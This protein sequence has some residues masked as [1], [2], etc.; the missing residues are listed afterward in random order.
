MVTSR[1]L[2]ADH[3]LT[4]LDRHALR[5]LLGAFLEPFQDWPRIDF[6]RTTGRRDSTRA[7]R[8]HVEDVSTRLGAMRVAHAS[9]PRLRR[10]SRGS[11]LTSSGRHA[12][13]KSL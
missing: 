12:W 2:A 13:P 11:S 5:R 7:L 4:S 8:L 1:S 9:L 10:R 6:L 3:L